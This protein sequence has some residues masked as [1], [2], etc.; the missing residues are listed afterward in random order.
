MIQVCKP[1]HMQVF[2][3]KLAAFGFDEIVL[4]QNQEMREKWDDVKLN[5]TPTRIRF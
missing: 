1:N 5:K 2:Y 3:F 4:M